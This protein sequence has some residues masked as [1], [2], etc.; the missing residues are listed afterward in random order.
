MKQPPS[1]VDPLRVQ[2]MY[3]NLIRH[4]M[5]SNRHQGPWHIKLSAK[6]VQLGFMISK[7]DTSLFIYNKSG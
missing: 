6:L 3:V 4:Y 5:D 2:T 1:Y 7:V